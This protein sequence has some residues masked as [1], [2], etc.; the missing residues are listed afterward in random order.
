MEFTPFFL[1]PF[2]LFP[3]YFGPVPILMELLYGRPYFTTALI[4]FRVS[5]ALSK[6]PM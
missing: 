2:T 3:K 5:S 6:A 1:S 4:A